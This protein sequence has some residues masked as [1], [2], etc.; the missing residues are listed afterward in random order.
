MDLP[1]SILRTLRPAQAGIATLAVTVLLLTGCGSTS[2]SEADG[3]G[4]ADTVSTSSS[5]TS[6]ATVSTTPTTSTEPAEVSTT[7]ASA[8]P[9][10]SEGSDVTETPEEVVSDDDVRAFN[11]RAIPATVTNATDAAALFIDI[12]RQ[13]RVD[14]QPA[15]AYADLGHTE[16]LLIRSIMRNPEWIE[17]F[18][19][20]LPDDLRAVAELHI[21][22]RTELSQLHANWTP[23]DNIPA[24]AIIDPEPLDTLVGHY[25]SASAETGIDWPILAG[26]NLIETGMGRIDGLSS[27]G[28][29]GP[30]QF[31]PT[32]WPEVSNGGDV[33]DPEDAIHGAARY[34]VRRGGLDDIR[35]GLWG[36]NN[37]DHYVNA[38]LAYAEMIRVDEKALRGFY[39]WEIYVGSAE[40]TLWLPVGYSSAEVASAKAYVAENPWVK[41]LD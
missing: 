33:R 13:L 21:E 22:A 19:A 14:D 32:T 10:T 26:I 11:G 28:A 15:E 36:Y 24:W 9:E 7:S 23:T 27:A 38:V 39:N 2:T 30:M 29:Q 5:T 8:A 6:A 25:K 12:E 18:L 34:L 16:Q 31:L 3:A 20:A 40:G 37:S 1:P 4:E 35:D 41:T 17:P